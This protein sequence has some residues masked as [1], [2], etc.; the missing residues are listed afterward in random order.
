M[1]SR[2]VAMASGNEF[3]EGGE[4]ANL[5]QVL[6]AMCAGSIADASAWLVFRHLLVLVCIREHQ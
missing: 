5:D 4:V 6:L 2:L 3:V 1:V